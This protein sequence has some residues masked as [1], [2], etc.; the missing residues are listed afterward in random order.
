MDDV[1][2][3]VRSGNLH[4]DS[5]ARTALASRYIFHQSPQ[6]L[7]TPHPKKRFQK[8]PSVTEASHRRYVLL[9]QL[10]E[11]MRSQQRI[12]TADDEPRGRRGADVRGDEPGGGSY[13]NAR[14]VVDGFDVL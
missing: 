7:G 10:L 6:C 2:E 9:D 1:Q 12:V 3:K 8:P 14:G 5:H 11:S 13:G 4:T